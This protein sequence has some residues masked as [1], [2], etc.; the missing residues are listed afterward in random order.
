MTISLKTKRENV[1]FDFSDRINLYTHLKQPDM[2]NYKHANFLDK[3]AIL[4]SIN[5]NLC[6]RKHEGEHGSRYPLISQGEI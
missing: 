1:Q 4:S 6:P 2:R 3:A 5:V